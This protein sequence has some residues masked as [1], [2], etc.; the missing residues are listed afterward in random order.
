[1]NG[2]VQ[3]TTQVRDET[4][5]GVTYHIEGELVPILTLELSAMPVFFEHH[6]LLWKEPRVD[7]DIKSIKSAVK[8]LIAGTPLLT[9]YAKGPGR[10]AVSRDGVGQII[11]IHLEAGRELHVREQQFLAATDNLDFTVER[12][13]GAASMLFSGTGFFIEKFIATKGDGLLWLHGYGN[14]YEVELGPGEQLDVEPGGWI[15]KDPS[16]K[17][18]TKLQKLKTGLFASGG[19]IVWNRFTGPGKLAFQSMSYQPPVGSEST[20]AG[21]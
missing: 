14:V 13:Q 3:L 6:V 8:R 17:L 18:E 2:P 11:P 16:V 1:M 10:I 19:S 15:Y 20:S 21:Q 9:T 7:I 5:A 12:V 4:Y